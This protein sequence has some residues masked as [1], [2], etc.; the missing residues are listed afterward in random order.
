MKLNQLN[1]AKLEAVAAPRVV[2]NRNPLRLVEIALDEPT[3]LMRMQHDRTPWRCYIRHSDSR[4]TCHAPLVPHPQYLGA[5][6]DAFMYTAG[7]LKKRGDPQKLTDQ[8]LTLL[9]ASSAKMLGH[10]ARLALGHF[11]EQELAAG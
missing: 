4:C 8:D 9:A 7:A 3:A 6:E 5:V 2:V 10:W 11:P 1:P